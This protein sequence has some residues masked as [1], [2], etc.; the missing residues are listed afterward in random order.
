MT[1]DTKP[2]KVF[3][4]YSH[5]DRKRRETLGDHLSLLQRE[6][7]IQEWHDGCIQAGQ[8]WEPEIHQQLE[9]AHLILLLISPDFMTHHSLYKKA[10]NLINFIFINHK[11]KL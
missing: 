3:Y 9:A 6:G 2:I 1:T 10:K 11:L 4:S 7:L 8:E 5:E